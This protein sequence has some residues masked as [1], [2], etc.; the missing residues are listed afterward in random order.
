MDTSCITALNGKRCGENRAYE[1][2]TAA[3]W[4][5]YYV[6]EVKKPRRSKAMLESTGSCIQEALLRF[7]P[8]LSPRP[9]SGINLFTAGDLT[10]E[11]IAREGW[12][13]AVTPERVPNI[14]KIPEKLLIRDQSG[15]N[16]QMVAIALQ[17][18]R[19][20]K[21]GAG[22]GGVLVF[23]PE[24]EIVDRI[25][26]EVFRRADGSLDMAV[27]SEVIDNDYGFPASLTG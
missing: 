6:D 21:H 27:N 26:Y 13:E 12:A 22:L 23:G 20:K 4:G 15:S 11:A 9:N 14:A 8:R 10:F 5:G 7:F 25:T 18:R 17:G 19:R 24:N 16:L 1:T 3:E 2:I